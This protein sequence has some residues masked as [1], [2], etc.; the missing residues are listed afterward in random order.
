M[1]RR[2]DLLG[3]ERTFRRVAGVAVGLGVLLGAA[4]VVRADG[5]PLPPDGRTPEKV[6]YATPDRY[7]RIPEKDGDQALI[8]KTAAPLKDK[9]AE[10]TFRNIHAF[11][12]R[13]PHVPERWEAEYRDFGKLLPG[14]DHTG[15]ACHALLFATLARACGIPAIYVKSSRHEWIRGY[16]ATGERGGFDGHVFLEVLVGGRW[17]LLDAQGMQIWDAYDTSDPELPGGLLAYEKGWDH[18]AMVHSTRRDEFIK[19]ALARWKDFDVSKLRKNETPGRALLPEVFAITVGGEWELLTKRTQMS[20]TFD[21]GYWKEWAP[22]VKGKILLVTSIAGRVGIPDAEV[23]AWLP[24]PPGAKAARA[25]ASELR[26]R[27]LDDG[28]LVVLLSAPGWN[29]LMALIW[30]TDFEQ[31]RCDFARPK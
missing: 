18:Y 8:K 6:D 21:R 2:L 5:A 12:A 15:C 1:R 10:Q 24:P 30:S 16:V 3:S 28:T 22:K 14:F 4:V 25:S 19:E 13:L 26:T 31:I 17:K 23:E 9:D 11:I 29:E 7:V 27:R 20:M